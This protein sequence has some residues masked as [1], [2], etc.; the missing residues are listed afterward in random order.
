MSEAEAAR[1]S[2]LP[3]ASASTSSPVE[4]QG[5]IQ[6][7][8]QQK[9]ATVQKTQSLSAYYVPGTVPGSEVPARKKANK[10]LPSWVLCTSGENKRQTAV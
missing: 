10:T 8:N 6:R 3:T 9:Q 1:A 4:I 5:R 7:S 2:T